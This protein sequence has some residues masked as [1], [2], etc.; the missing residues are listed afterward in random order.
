MFVPGGGLDQAGLVLD[1]GSRSETVADASRVTLHGHGTVQS[2]AISA[3]GATLYACSSQGTTMTIAAYDTAT[4]ARTRVL[5]DW[6]VAQRTDIICD[7]STDAS[8]GYLLASVTT[9]DPATDTSA[10]QSGT[11]LTGYRL[12]RATAVTIPLQLASVSGWGFI[13]W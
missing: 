11:T 7:L 10:A 5:R 8:G 3:N 9:T 2:V 1:T 6:R 12:G 4:G 13:A